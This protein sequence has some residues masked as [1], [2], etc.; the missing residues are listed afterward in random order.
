M[1]RRHDRACDVLPDA[2]I[3]AIAARTAPIAR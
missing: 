1:R 3:L 2:F